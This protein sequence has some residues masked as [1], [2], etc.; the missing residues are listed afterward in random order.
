MFQK[1][2]KKKGEKQGEG[3]AEAPAPSVSTTG[4]YELKKRHDGCNGMF[5]REDPTGKTSLESN[6]NWPHDGAILRGEVVQAKGET[7]LLCKELKQRGDS[8]FK[9]APRGA[10]MPFEYNDHYYL[11]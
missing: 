11:E 3:G 6:N 2:F 5:W 4:D 8:E 7:W 9:S 1:L 10:A